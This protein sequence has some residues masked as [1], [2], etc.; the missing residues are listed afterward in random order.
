MRRY[1]NG[2]HSRVETV[3][4]CILCLIPTLQKFA[5]TMYCSPYISSV[6][7]IN[8][9]F[10]VRIVVRTLSNVNMWR[11]AVRQEAINTVYPTF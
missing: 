1:V 7:S 10:N 2:M 11:H 5:V 9:D 3:L 4:Q 8:H 6:K